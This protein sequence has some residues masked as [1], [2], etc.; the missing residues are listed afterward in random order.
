MYYYVGALDHPL[1]LD[2]G[3]QSVRTSL[4]LSSPTH[5]PIHIHTRHTHRYDF[6]CPIVDAKDGVTHA[7]R[8]TEYKLRDELYHWLV[9]KLKLRHIYIQEF[10]R[11]NFNYTVVSKRKLR[12]LVELKEV[13]DWKDPRFPTVQGIL[14]RGVQF[15]AMRKFIL[16]Q[17]FSTKPINM[18]WD[19][20]WSDNAKILDKNCPRYAM[21]GKDSAVKVEVEGLGDEVSGL[22]VDLHPKDPSFGQCV[23]SVYKELLIE[24]AD[25]NTIEE[26]D[27]VT[28]M[29]LGNIKIKSVVKDKDGNVTLIKAVENLSDTNY[30]KTKKIAWVANVKNLVEVKKVE[31]DF[32]INKKKLEKGD[33]LEDFLTSKKNP[34][35]AT[36]I[37]LAD[38]QIKRLKRDEFLQVYRVGYFRCD[39]AFGSGDDSLEMF[40]IPDG[41]KKAMS[42]LGTNKLKHR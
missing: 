37:L 8:T 14:R 9:K 2:F 41:K 26:G 6:A 17:G 22:S 28:F 42:T 16:G 31:F 34:T 4:Y 36:T 7:M 27:I 30:K 39:K 3:A 35:K 13:E 1:S 20:F 5:S 29:R 10:G 23:I 15:E 40:L 11:L 21:I 25:A 12:K 18:E 32:L 24:S 38:P 33:E 19:K